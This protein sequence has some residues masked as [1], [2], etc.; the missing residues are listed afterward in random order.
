MIWKLI[1]LKFQLKGDRLVTHLWAFCSMS[2]LSPQSRVVV[3]IT[4]VVVKM[5][6]CHPRKW[7]KRRGTRWKKGCSNTR[8]TPILHQILTTGT[9]KYET[10]Y[11][12]CLGPEPFVSNW[13]TFDKRLGLSVSLP[14][15][16]SY[17]PFPYQLTVPCRFSLRHPPIPWE[18]ELGR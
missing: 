12:P 15:P 17:H 11:D 16:S 14:P 7:Q 4:T 6:Q 5:V 18:P 9:G 1:Y 10:Y 13:L 8:R 3:V 2:V